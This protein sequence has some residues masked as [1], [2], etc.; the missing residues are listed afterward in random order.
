MNRLQFNKLAFLL[1]LAI[2]V[3]T[4]SFAQQGQLTV[5]QDQKIDELLTLKKEIDASDKS[6]DR[7]KIQIEYGNRSKVESARS[8]YLNSY[9]NWSSTIVYETPNYKVWVGNFR[10]RLEADRAL[11]KIKKKFPHA[12]IFKPKKEKD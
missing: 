8:R 3:S 12:F 11:V 9:S 10:T 1:L 4:L 5:N 6:G 7:Y 2:T